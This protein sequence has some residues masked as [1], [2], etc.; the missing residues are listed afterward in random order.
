MSGDKEVRSAQYSGRL[1]APKFRAWH[2]SFCCSDTVICTEAQ[3][4]SLESVPVGRPGKRDAGEVKAPFE[5]TL[6]VQTC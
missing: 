3:Q 2:R 4:D 6:R 1:R 5:N